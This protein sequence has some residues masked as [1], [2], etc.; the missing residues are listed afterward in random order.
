MSETTIW[1][2]VYR[3]RNLSAGV[4]VAELSTHQEAEQVVSNLLEEDSISIS[5]ICVYEA[6]VRKIN[7]RIEE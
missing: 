3:D 7:L 2:V 4:N 1:I 5:D 6:F